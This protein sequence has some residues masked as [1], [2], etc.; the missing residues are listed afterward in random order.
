VSLH[1]ADRTGLDFPREESAGT[2][3]VQPQHDPA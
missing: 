3:S 1:P 2:V